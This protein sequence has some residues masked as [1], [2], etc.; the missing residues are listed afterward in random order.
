[1]GWLFVALFFELL[2]HWALGGSVGFLKKALVALSLLVIFQ[3][4]WGQR[5]Q[6]RNRERRKN[7]VESDGVAEAEC[8]R[9]VCCTPSGS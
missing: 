1:V 3:R 6:G 2:E 8:I 7:E 4:L 9:F 5:V